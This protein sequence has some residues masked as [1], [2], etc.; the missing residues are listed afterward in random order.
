LSEQHDPGDDDEIRE[1]LQRIETRLDAIEQKLEKS[2]RRPAVFQQLV[3]I[4]T[5]GVAAGALIEIIRFILA[6]STVAPSNETISIVVFLVA[7]INLVAFLS[8]NTDERTDLEEAR[9]SIKQ[10]RS[11]FPEDSDRDLSRL[12]DGATSEYDTSSDSNT[13][14]TSSAQS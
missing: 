14:K 12:E 10:Q 5:G 2:S 8:F 3:I 1:V 9:E 11:Q 7:V 4:L 13:D 6:G